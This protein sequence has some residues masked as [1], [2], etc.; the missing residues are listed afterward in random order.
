M[1]LTGVGE[2][3]QGRWCSQ[4]TSLADFSCHVG[5]TDWGGQ[6]VKGPKQMA[7][8]SGRW[9]L[10]SLSLGRWSPCP[11]ND[12]TQLQVPLSCPVT[13]DTTILSQLTWVNGHYLGNE[14]ASWGS[15]SA[16]EFYYPIKSPGV[17]RELSVCLKGQ[18]WKSTCCKPFPCLLIGKRKMST[19]CHLV[20]ST[21]HYCLNEKS[22]LNTSK[23]PGSL[24]V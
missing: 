14:I 12:Q 23:G 1:L 17:C 19:Y 8:S 13:Q 15:D 18:R 21:D 22:S 10:F 5:L 20:G 7:A 16:V 6:E 2:R 11:C 3:T 24:P 9:C 4:K